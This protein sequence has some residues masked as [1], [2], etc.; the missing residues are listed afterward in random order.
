[1]TLKTQQ[2]KNNLIQKWAKDLNEHFSR[3]DIQISSLKMLSISNIRK[4]QIK[5]IVR[6]HTH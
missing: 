2:Q 4:I 3:K 6:Y 5:T 1:M